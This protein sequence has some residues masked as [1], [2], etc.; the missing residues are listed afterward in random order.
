[1][2]ETDRPTSP[3]GSRPHDL[4][5]DELPSWIDYPLPFM[6]I[7]K[8]S[9]FVI[10]P[11]ASAPLP[12][13]RSSNTQA[14]RDRD[15]SPDTFHAA[16]STSP[17]GSTTSSSS[18]SHSLVKSLKVTT[19]SRE[20]H[21]EIRYVFSDDD[22]APTIDVLDCR[23]G[24]NGNNNDVSLILD[25]DESGTR[26]V[27]ATSLSSAWQI[28]SVTERVSTN[29]PAPAWASTDNDSSVAHVLFVEGT[30]AVP[31]FSTAPPLPPLPSSK[32]DTRRAQS[33]RLQTHPASHPLT[34]G[35]GGGSKTAKD[36]SVGHDTNAAAAA[37]VASL[38]SSAS[39]L[40]SDSR[41]GGAHNT[42]NDVSS[43]PLMQQLAIRALTEQFL[44]R[45]RQLRQML[46]SINKDE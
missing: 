6:V 41:S 18:S 35:G 30:S 24:G 8:D 33:P 38:S 45:N 1:M 10:S 20:I 9:S 17:V 15:N 46:N 11:S 4:D 26:A 31:K 14:A 16:S 37:S 7:V 29:A 28:S 44:E 42:Q 22:F 2:A 19:Q 39:S 27:N 5:P 40:G 43:S 25:F 32:D 36:Y 34:G 3:S 13:L 12:P 23:Q 21:P